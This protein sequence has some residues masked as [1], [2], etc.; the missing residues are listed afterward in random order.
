M[1]ARNTI[2][3]RNICN[4][5]DICTSR[6]EILHSGI[7]RD[8]QGNNI[9]PGLETRLAARAS[10]GAYIVMSVMR[11]WHSYLITITAIA[12]TKSGNSKCNTLQIMFLLIHFQLCYCFIHSH[13]YL[14]TFI[15][16]PK[17]LFSQ[18][19]MVSACFL[20]S[21]PSKD[22]FHNTSSSLVSKYMDPIF[23]NMDIICLLQF[24]QFDD[25]YIT[26]YMKPYSC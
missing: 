2:Q 15:H 21:V 24:L 12:V 7:I 19:Q 17:I 16:P 10:P 14:F 11:C 6:I 5:A 22:H 18:T 1:E 8:E 23:Y 9:G 4:S 3:H 13:R 26:H 25:C 20:P